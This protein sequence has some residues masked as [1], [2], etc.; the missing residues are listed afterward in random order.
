M[1]SSFCSRKSHP[2]SMVKASPK[3]RRVVLSISHRSSGIAEIRP[4]YADCVCVRV[5][6]RCSMIPS[7]SVSNHSTSYRILPEISFTDTTL[8]TL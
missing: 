3:S 8:H 4:I 7:I 1:R 5:S 6:L 2:E